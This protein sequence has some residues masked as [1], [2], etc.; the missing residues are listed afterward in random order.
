MPLP[1]EVIT[2]TLTYGP[3]G[4]YTGS[5]VP[6]ASVIV[7]PDADLVW[8]DTG[9]PLLRTPL[10]VTG[11]SGELE[12]PATDQPG[13]ITSDGVVTGFTYTARMRVQGQA[14]RTVTFALPTLGLSGQ[15]FDLDTMIAIAPGVV[16]DPVP[17]LDDLDTAVQDAAD[18]AA[19][20][21]TSA[22]A[23]ATSAGAAAT[24]AGAAATSAGAAATSAS[25]AATSASS[26][27]TS[28]SSAA[29]A[30]AAVPAWWAGTQV[31]YDALPVKDPA[32][33]YV[34]TG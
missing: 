7:T 6:A 33:L 31:A 12:L 26:A 3:L 1:A 34:I 4:D 32:T 5:P 28:A 25:S 19:E 16:V 24:S 29:T 10:E 23:A 27:A 9:Q 17:W 30:A 2:A 20:A 22:T 18:S 15:V 21:G 11:L 13:F 14:D 8:A